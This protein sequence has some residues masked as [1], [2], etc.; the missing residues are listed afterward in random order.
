MR[1]FGVVPFNP[2]SNGR[3][4]F[5]EIAKVILPHAFFLET[6]K[7]ALDETVLLGCIGRDEF[8]AQA[9]IAA[10]GTKTPTLKDE[11]IVAPNYRCSAVGTQ[12]ISIL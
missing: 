4:G 6:T 12:L 7:E 11:A 8:L 5:G 2:L 9:V 1:P 3:P 10:G